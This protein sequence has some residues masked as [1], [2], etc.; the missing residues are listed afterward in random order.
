MSKS[1][2]ILRSFNALSSK[3]KFSI[4]E[5]YFLIG[6]FDQ[7][8]VQLWKKIAAK[9]KHNCFPD[10]SIAFIFVLFYAQKFVGEIDTNYVYRKRK[11]G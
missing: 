4:F 8:F 10:L 6:V 11:I 2:I 9:Q 5:K 1:L 3:L 7:N